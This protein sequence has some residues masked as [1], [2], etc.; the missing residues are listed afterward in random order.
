[1]NDSPPLFDRPYY[2]C[3][4][5]QGAPRNHFVTIVSAADDDT[6]DTEQLT[7]AILNGN[8][9]QAFSIESSTGEKLELH[10]SNPEP[11][12]ASILYD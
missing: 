11:I 9:A 7:Y 3:W 4:V 10:D 1:M 8:A 12:L 6:S 2:R 5:S